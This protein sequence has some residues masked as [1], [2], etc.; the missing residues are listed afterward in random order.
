MTTLDS[1]TRLLRYNVEELGRSFRIGM[2]Q[3]RYTAS[4]VAVAAIAFFALIK[5]NGQPAGVILWTL[6]GTTNQMLAA[7]GLLVATIMLYK[8]G[9]P[10][11]YTLFPML[12]MV[13]SVTWAIAMQLAQ[14]YRGAKNN[15]LGSLLLLIV[16]SMLAILATWL[17]IEGFGAFLRARRR[18]EPA[19][20]ATASS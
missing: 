4:L 2:V 18:T 11:V 13:V 17:T 16:G 10:I 1:A 19:A 3:N 15:D 7:L 8:L 9:K 20:S 14:F 6:F 12:V 5:I